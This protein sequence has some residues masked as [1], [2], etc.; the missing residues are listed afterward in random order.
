MNAV[1]LSK[2]PDSTLQ[3]DGKYLTFYL[4]DNSYGIAILKVNE[5]IGVV[6]ITQVP[7]TPS[8]VKGIIN[9]RGRIIPVMDLRLKFG[10]SERDYDSNT[11]IIIINLE[12]KKVT[13]QVGLIVDIVSEV[14]SIPASEIEA[15]PSC[16]ANEEDDFISGVGKIKDKVIMLLDIEKVIFSDDLIHLFKHE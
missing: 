6:D 4:N 5:I 11:C 16:G 1:Q 13:K 8:Y 2:N 10:I 7:K 3:Q 15:S 9:L 12:V 14:C